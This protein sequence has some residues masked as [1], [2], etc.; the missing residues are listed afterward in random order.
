MKAPRS[1]PAEGFWDILLRFDTAAYAG[2]NTLPDTQGVVFRFLKACGIRVQKTLASQPEVPIDVLMPLAPRILT[3]DLARDGLDPRVIAFFAH[4]MIMLRDHCSV[5]IKKSLL[6]K[7]LDT[8]VLVGRQTVYD[9]NSLEAEIVYKRLGIT[10]HVLALA[11]KWA[12]AGSSNTSGSYHRGQWSQL[13][14]SRIKK[15]AQTESP[16][17]RRSTRPRTR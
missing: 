4:Y 2:V 3:G 1:Y 17:H 7:I 14:T 5:K 15:K 11:K 10:C 8:T 9:V 13:Q 16:G 12:I 6:E